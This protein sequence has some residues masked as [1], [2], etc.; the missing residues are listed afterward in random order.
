MLVL[1]DNLKEENMCCVVVVVFQAKYRFLYKKRLF[2]Q[3]Y[4]H[5]IMRFK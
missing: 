5:T 3:N 4:A 1:A 2:Y